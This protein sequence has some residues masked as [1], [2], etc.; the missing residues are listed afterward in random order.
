MRFLRRIFKDQVKF[1]AI[2]SGI[3]T[4][5]GT[6]VALVQL[7]G[8]QPSVT[9]T[10]TPTTTLRGDSTLGP[11]PS[12]SPSVSLSTAATTAPTIDPSSSASIGQT[13]GSYKLDINTLCNIEGVHANVS[14][15]AD[16]DAQVGGTLFHYQA[17]SSSAWAAKPPNYDSVI[18]VPANTCTSLVVSFAQDDRLSKPGSTANM[19]VLQENAPT[20]TAAIGYGKVGMFTV[21]LN[22]GAFRLQANTTGGQPVYVSGYALCSTM[23]GT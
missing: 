15:S 1:W 10:A 9:P 13:P 12:P 6:S 8:G 2:T 7:T 23:S 11:L 14:C 17:W 16:A 21:K 5:I 19:R 18:E 20:A 4:V 22:G 3:A